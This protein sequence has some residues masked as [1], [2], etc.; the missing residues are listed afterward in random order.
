[1]NIS[2]GTE[3]D[4]MKYLKF[5]YVTKRGVADKI[6]TEEVGL[7]TSWGA[8]SFLNLIVCIIEKYAGRDIAVIISKAFVIDIDRYSQLPFI[9]FPGQKAHD[10]E[11]IKKPRNK[12]KLVSRIK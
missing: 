8:Y 3:K 7:Y 2:L 5:G 1:M 10:D 11:P 12:Q 4:K 9:I 6:M